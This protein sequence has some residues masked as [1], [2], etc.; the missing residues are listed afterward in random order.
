MATI[1]QI[2]VLFVLALASAGNLP[3]V[4]HHVTCHQTASEAVQ[5][6]SHCLCS[7]ACQT[8]NEPRSVVVVEEADYECGVCYQL[9]QV[10]RLSCDTLQVQSRPLVSCV[11]AQV[12]KLSLTAVKCSH[13]PRGPPAA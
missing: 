4:A 2:M 6:G 8:A 10:S 9:S 13:S 5:A 11:V 3:L 1:R 7:H 12:T